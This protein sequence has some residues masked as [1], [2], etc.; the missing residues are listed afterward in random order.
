LEHFRLYTLRW[1]G[2]VALAGCASAAPGGRDFAPIDFGVPKNGDLAQPELDLSTV[3]PRD[4]SIPI[5][6]PDMAMSG[7]N[8]DMSMSGSCTPPVSGT[9]DTAPQCGCTG[10]QA[11]SVVDNSTGATGCVAA[12]STPNYS[13]CTGSGAGQCLAGAS[14]VD[15][16]CE[17]YCNSVA[18][19]PGPYRQCTQVQT[20]GVNIP[21]FL[22][23]TRTCDSQNPT[24]DN[25]TFDPCGP[26]V[27][28]LPAT[29]G[30]STCVAPTNPAGTYLAGCTDVTD[31]AVGHLCVGG[32]CYQMCHYDPLGFGDC[33]D[34]SLTCYELTPAYYAGPNEIGVC[35]F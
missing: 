17:Q 10:G 14:C 1:L 3:T 28:C 4:L 11:C 13:A 23:C 20:G 24:L 5:G 35:D 21:G 33:T 22:T 6:N 32:T 15:G 18:D 19:C 34:T 2:C 9:C 29:D 31:C 16:V 30:S 7:R 25:S 26:G 27:N 12:G 8:P